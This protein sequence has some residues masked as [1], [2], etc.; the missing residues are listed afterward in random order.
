[1]SFVQIPGRGIRS[2]VDL[3]QLNKHVNR[4]IHPPTEPQSDNPKLTVLHHKPDTN[5]SRVNTTA[6]CAT[7]AHHVTTH[8]E[9]PPPI[10][11]PRRYTHSTDRLASRIELLR[12]KSSAM[13]QALEKSRE[14]LVEG[15]A[16]AP[17]AA[18][19]A[20]QWVFRYDN[21]G[22]LEK[23]R[24]ELVEGAATAP[25]ATAAAATQ[26]VSR[27]DNVGTQF[28]DTTT[29]AP[30]FLIRQRQHPVSRYDNVGT[31]SHHRYDNVGTQFHH[32]YDNVGTQSNTAK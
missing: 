17:A 21:V 29:S 12:A 28:P 13:F 32:R 9:T 16:A 18:A 2:V 11:S 26:W 1:M 15:A 6:V 5:V 30:S 19:T 22:T 8:D 4:P 31:Q 27:Y 25:A 3:V 14:E 10:A 23:S 24:E 7:V 20:A